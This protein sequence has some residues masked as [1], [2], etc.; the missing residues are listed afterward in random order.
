MTQKRHLRQLSLLFLC[1]SISAQLYSVDT[2]MGI[3]ELV[4]PPVDAGQIPQTTVSRFFNRFCSFLRADFHMKLYQWSSD[5]MDFHES[6]VS[7]DTWQ[8]VEAWDSVLLETTDTDF[9]STLQ[10]EMANTLFPYVLG[11]IGVPTSL[12]VEPTAV[13]SYLSGNFSGWPA[14]FTSP[15]LSQ[16]TAILLGYESLLSVEILGVKP[17][18]S[19]TPGISIAE[20]TTVGSETPAS[21]ARATLGAFSTST[22]STTISTAIGGDVSATSSSQ[23]SISNS[24]ASSLLYHHVFL[25]D[26]FVALLS[27]ATLTIM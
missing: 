10:A 3:F 23:S 17:T 20:P 9:L 24:S 8:W 15:L 22:S 13:L 7:A 16:A 19:I 12:M 26:T 11:T 25:F 5:C 4:T 14:T 1:S 2:D 27:L 21:G 6:Y 18:A